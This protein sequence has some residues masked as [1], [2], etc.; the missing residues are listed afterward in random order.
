MEKERFSS[1]TAEQVN[2]IQ[3]F[4]KEFQTKYGQSVYLLA[5]NQQNQ[6]SR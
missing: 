3:T 4:E 1:L 5:F 2:T 6:K